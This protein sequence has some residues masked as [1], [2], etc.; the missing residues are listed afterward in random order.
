[1]LAPVHPRA[2]AERIR[3]SVVDAEQRAAS[4]LIVREE[5]SGAR[6]VLA[7]ALAP[8]PVAEPAMV[9]HSSAAVRTAVAGG[10]GCALLSELVVAAD[11][12]EG[13]LVRIPVRGVNLRRSL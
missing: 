11:L 5:G 2:E 6:E 7:T 3:S 12:R 1:V 4:A 13:R 8:R 10:A 9:L